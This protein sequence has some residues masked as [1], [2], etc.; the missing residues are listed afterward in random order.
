MSVSSSFDLGLNLFK[1]EGVAYTSVWY[2]IPL[3]NIQNGS[4]F[5]SEYQKMQGVFRKIY[6]KVASKF[7]LNKLN[8]SC[9]TVTDSSGNACVCMDFHGRL[10]QLSVGN[11]RDFLDAEGIQYIDHSNS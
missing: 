11:L 9:V 6:K 4:F 1:G 10:D 3:S 5:D 8:V 7:N 2:R